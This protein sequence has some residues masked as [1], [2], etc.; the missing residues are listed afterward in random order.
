MFLM[1]HVKCS[2]QNRKSRPNGT[3]VGKPI[4]HNASQLITSVFHQ[5]LNPGESFVIILSNWLQGS[6]KLELV[7][8]TNESVWNLSSTSSE[9]FTK[10][11]LKHNV[12][13]APDHLTYKETLPNLTVL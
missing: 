4:F 7:F 11:T 6:D 12:V 1:F 5:F 13:T 8:E 3:R 9:M 2:G 10:R